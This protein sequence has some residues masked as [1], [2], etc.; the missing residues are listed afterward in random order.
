LRTFSSP[1]SS[2]FKVT[3]SAFCAVSQAAR[4]VANTVLKATGRVND[5]RQILTPYRI[6]T[7]DPIAAKFDTFDYYY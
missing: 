5:K 7:L 1:V 3:I 4:V 6:G 2:G